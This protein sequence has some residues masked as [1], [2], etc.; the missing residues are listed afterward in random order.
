MDFIEITTPLTCCAE[1]DAP[2]ARRDCVS[3]R[4]YTLRGMKE[5]TCVSSVAP[6]SYAG[7]LTTTTF[8]VWRHTLAL[9]DMEYIFIN[10]KVGFAIDFLD[11]HAALQ[12]RGPL[13]N[14][15]IEHA[16]SESLWGIC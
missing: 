10:S 15:T 16:Q 14:N 2:F 7:S 3:A 11:Y 9:E 1:F 4:L 12:F 8:G 6:P 5:V 13:S